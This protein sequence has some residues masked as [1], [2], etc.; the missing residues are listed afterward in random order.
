MRSMAKSRQSPK[1]YQIP[2]G[3][4]CRT[5]KAC[6]RN[7]GNHPNVIGVGIGLKF[8][9]GRPQSS[10]NCVHFYVR[11][12]VKRFYPARKLPKFVYARRSNGTVDYSHK[13]W[14]DV[15]ELK[16]LKF[17]CRSG[18]EIR[19]DWRRRHL[20]ITVSKQ[21][22]RSKQLLSYNMRACCRRCPAVYSV[23]PRITS[24]CCKTGAVLATTIVNSTERNGE[25]DYDIALA[26]L[27]SECTPQPDCQIV[28]SA[29]VLRRFLPSNNIRAGMRLDCAFPI[30][31]IISATVSSLRTSLP[32][33]LDG[34]DQ[35]NNLFLIDQTPRRGDSG[36]I[37][38]DGDDAAGILVGMA[39]G[40]GLFQPLDEAFQHLQNIAPDPNQV[41]LI[42]HCKGREEKMA[43]L[44]T[45]CLTILSCAI[46]AG[47]ATDR[48]T[49]G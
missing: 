28:G 36:G 49:E 8:K 44:T 6:E 38:H 14:T 35:V 31:N 33:F 23:D 30:S 3:M 20:N 13:I 11:R 46:F 4:L 27:T 48:N 21:D 10:N 37:L 17:A 18:T 32:L 2:Q 1:I 12:K 25:V 22:F 5:Q 24:S 42:K 15:I 41:F 39:D 29:A 40:W 43:K 45:F 26:K 9:R 16:S 47:C 34:R 19:G 7:Y